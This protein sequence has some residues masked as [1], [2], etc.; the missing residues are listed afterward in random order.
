MADF[1][2]TIE[3]LGDDA[4][5]DSIIDGTITEFKDDSVTVVGRAAFSN[6]TA[7]ETVWLPN[8]TKLVDNAF[9]RC[10]ALA[11]V[12]TPNVVELCGN[13][14]S[15]TGLREAD[16]PNCTDMGAHVFYGCSSLARAN[17]PLLESVGY[18]AFGQCAALSEFYAPILTSIMYE[19]FGVCGKLERIDLPMLTSIA[20]RGFRLSAL[21]TLILRNTSSVVTLE[22]VDGVARTPIADGTG[23][24]YVPKALVDSYKSASNWSTYAT[25]FRAL[26]DYTVDGTITGALDETKI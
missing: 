2:N 10:A 5:V 7:L 21:S 17:F 6:C 15:E 12:N 8:A 26:E 20:S 18:Q 3:V 22:N 16:F 14:L 25:K 19:A 4:V 13:A 1:I 24:I 9:E 23:Y 11:D